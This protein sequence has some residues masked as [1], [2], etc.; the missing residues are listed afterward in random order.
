VLLGKLA[1]GSG[2]IIRC[3]PRS[4]RKG[5]QGSGCDA[6]YTPT[7]WGQEQLFEAEVVW[8]MDRVCESCQG[9]FTAA[10]QN[11][12]FCS[13]RCARKVR[14]ARY[15]QRRALK[16]PG[17]PIGREEDGVPTRA[18]QSIHVEVRLRHSEK[19]SHADLYEW[20]MD[21]TLKE[22]PIQSD[23]LYIDRT[24]SNPPRR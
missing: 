5:V 24:G 20:R 22:R 23:A 2:V 1:C 14:F 3:R 12:K 15:V 7:E 9:P 8:S 13:P 16:E 11:Q 10:K 21:L 17:L 6:R 18:E 19:H 4:R